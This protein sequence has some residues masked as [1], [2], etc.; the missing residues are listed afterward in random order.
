MSKSFDLLAMNVT[1]VM[2][3]VEEI[4]TASDVSC[5]ICNC[6]HSGGIKLREIK[7][8]FLKIKFWILKLIRLVIG[9]EHHMRQR[10]LM[11]CPPLIVMQL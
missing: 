7:S 3:S 6:G 11:A 2:K 4:K 1:K 5:A 10:S 9:E 8:L